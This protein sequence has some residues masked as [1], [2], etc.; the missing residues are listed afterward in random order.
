MRRS[1]ADLLHYGLRIKSKKEQTGLRESV[2]GWLSG[3]SVSLVRG[4]AAE[5]E[6]RS[7]AVVIKSYETNR[8][9]SWRMAHPV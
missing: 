9:T 1:A 5:L 7:V 3:Q 2:G 8:G 4:E 6:A